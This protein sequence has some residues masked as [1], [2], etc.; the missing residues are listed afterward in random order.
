MKILF[1]AVMSSLISACQPAPLTCEQLLKPVD[2]GPVITGK[3]YYIALATETCLPSTLFSSLLSP[4]LT[5]DVTSKDTAN[6][7]AART[8]VKMF[9]HCY[10]ESEAIFYDNNKMFDVDKNNAP[11]GEPDIVLQTSCP[12]CLVVKSAD[13]LDTVVFLS[14]RSVVTDAELREF[15]IQAK[16]LGWSKP[17]V[18]GTDHDYVNCKEL[19]MDG[20]LTEDQSTAML[21]FF[22]EKMQQSR[23]KIIK[24]LTEFIISYLPSYLT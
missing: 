20:D 22:A 13:V 6:V 2:K 17:E 1:V 12:D 18:L 8:Y 21:Q 19:D 11:T 23:Q 10:N 9:G 7:F 14:R 4:S 3:W 5:A 16:C 24:C 15:A